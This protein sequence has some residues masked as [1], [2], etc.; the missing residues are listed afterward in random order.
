MNRSLLRSALGPVAATML[1]SG[2]LLV[3]CASGNSRRYVAGTDT[4]HAVVQSIEAVPAG[5]GSAVAGTVIGGAVGA[6]VGHQFGQGRGNDL[7]T[8]AGAVGGAIVGHELQ[9]RANERRAATA[10]YRVRV[11]F[12]NGGERVY[13]LDDVGNLRVGDRVRVDDDHIWR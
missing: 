13:L 8:A 10:Q 4:R 11:R 3:G 6:V 2:L 5:S 9:Q 12:S 1:M 7:A